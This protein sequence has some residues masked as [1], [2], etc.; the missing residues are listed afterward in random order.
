MIKEDMLD[1]YS[2]EDVQE[3]RV[4]CDKVLKSRDDNRKSKAMEQ[5][6]ATLAA[7]GLTLNDLTRTKVRVPQRPKHNAGSSYQHPTNNALIG[8]GKGQR[9]KW[10]RELENNHVS[11]LEIP[12][13]W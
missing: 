12:K 11:P 6:R 1:A 7:A 5:A 8:N 3:V 4:L 13:R 9:P 2:D 10:L